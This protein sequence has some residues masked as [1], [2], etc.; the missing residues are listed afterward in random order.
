MSCTKYSTHGLYGHLSSLIHDNEDGY[1]IMS[2]DRAREKVQRGQGP[3]RAYRTQLDQVARLQLDPLGAS[4]MIWISASS[5][6]RVATWLKS[7]AE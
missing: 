3:Q 6:L 7:E 4:S 1:T 2:T 5:F